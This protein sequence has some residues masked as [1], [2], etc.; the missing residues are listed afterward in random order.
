MPDN[1]YFKGKCKLSDKGPK[2][3][4]K[5][6]LILACETLINWWKKRHGKTIVIEFVRKLNWGVLAQ[7]VFKLQ[8]N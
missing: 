2:K 4:D 5:A 6:D 1:K 8:H 3:H 7:S